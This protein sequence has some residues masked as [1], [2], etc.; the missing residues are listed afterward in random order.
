MQLTLRQHILLP[1]CNKVRFPLSKHKQGCMRVLLRLARYAFRYRSQI[2]AAWLTLIIAAGLQ[3]A[4]PW[5]MG[6]AIDEAL[7][8]GTSTRLWQLGGLILF[9]TVSRGAIQYLDVYLGESI[10][11]RVV[12]TLRNTL[13]DK[14]QRLSFAFHDKEHT[15]NL[16]SKATVDIDMVRMF[17]SFGLVRSL[18]LILLVGFVTVLLMQIDWPLALI[19]L[20]F[21]PILAI[22]ASLMSLKMRHMWRRVQQGMGEMTTVMQE[23]L[24]G[25]R[26]VK[27]FGAEEFEQSKFREKTESVFQET[28]R[29]ERLRASNTAVMQLVFWGATGLILWLGGRAVVEGRLTAG[30][31]A[32]FILYVSMLV[33]P[34]RMIGQMTSTFARAASSGERIFEVLDAKSD[35]QEKPGAQ[36]LK[37][38]R[39]RVA[40]EG[41]SFAY[42]SQPILDRISLTAEPGQVIALLGTAGSGK[43]TLLHLLARFYDASDG[44]ITIDGVNIKDVTL[45]SL[46]QTVGLVQQ[47][48]FLF[49][50]TVAENIAYGRPS[51]S[52]DEITTAATTAQLHQEIMEL[53]DGYDTVIGERGVTLSG[54]QRQRL[55]IARTLLLNPPVLVLDDSTSSVDAETEARIQQAMT[56]VVQG[57]TT[58]II[59][60]RLT[61]IQHASLIVVLDHGQIVEMGSSQELW[62]KEGF[63][64]HIAELQT[65]VATEAPYPGGRGPLMQTMRGSNS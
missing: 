4:V 11:H 21:V 50:A 1:H 39:G 18:S 44:R 58:F 63:Y 41:V 57:R 15:G 24:T 64:R 30:E 28:Y 13:Y 65:A 22:W 55:A 45:E 7:A 27:A 42:G 35:V 33:Q 9:V 25:M 5:L 6:T 61:S 60:H 14:L 23:N 26:V 3:V 2:V 53:S 54:G 17:I 37:N 56:N 31:L 29:T 36:P 40:F 48:V 46:R 43:T 10:S 59:A 12:Y 34:V 52:R 62:A 38:I 19:S 47:D 8:S 20:F 16:M 32:Q 51:A 49:S